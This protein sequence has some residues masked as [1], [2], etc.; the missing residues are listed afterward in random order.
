MRSI[1]AVM[2]AWLK[3]AE[4]QPEG[5]RPKPEVICRIRQT[6][7]ALE[8]PPLEPSPLEGAAIAS[9]PKRKRTKKPAL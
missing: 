2:K 3:W 4:A 5:A 1:P 8:P 7:A 6:L 9:A